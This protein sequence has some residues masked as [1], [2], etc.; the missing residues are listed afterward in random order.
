M[1]RVNHRVVHSIYRAFDWLSIL[2]FDLSIELIDYLAEWKSDYLKNCFINHS[3][4]DLWGNEWYDFLIGVLVFNWLSDWLNG[5]LSKWLFYWLKVRLTCRLVA[6]L[7]DLI[8]LFID[9]SCQQATFAGRECDGVVSVSDQ[10]WHHASRIQ[11][12]GL[13][14]HADW[15]TRWAWHDCQFLVCFV[16][17]LDGHSSM[18][19]SFFTMI[20]LSLVFF[21]LLLFHIYSVIRSLDWPTLRW[22]V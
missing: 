5:W 9:H 3:M 8:D 14:T 17:W 10:L 7:N 12:V 21:I 20:L 16:R 2:L 6:W 18:A 1:S 4:T 19:C 13:T 11:V 22:L 15:R